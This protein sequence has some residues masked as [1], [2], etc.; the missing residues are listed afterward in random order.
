[1]GLALC[2]D[3]HSTVVRGRDNEGGEH[4]A[5]PIAAVVG[6]YILGKL[7]DKSDAGAK[8]EIK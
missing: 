5:S 7:A 1:M 2:L 4:P 6:M 3:I 8:G